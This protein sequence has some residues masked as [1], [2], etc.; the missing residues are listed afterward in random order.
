YP[1]ERGIGRAIA[2]AVPALTQTPLPRAVEEALSTG[3]SR[4]V[5][6]LTLS[7][8]SSRSR[9]LEVRVLPVSDGVTLLWQDI[10]ERAPADYALKRSE[11]RLILA[12]EGANDG[13]WELDLRT[14][15]FYVSGRW[16]AM[17]GLTPAAGVRSPQERPQRAPPA[18]PPRVKDARD[19]HIAAKTD[20]C[21]REHRMRHEDGSY[22]R[23]LCRGIAARGAG[24]RPMRIAGSLTDTTAQ[25]TAQEQLRTAEYRDPLTGLCNSAVFVE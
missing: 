11:E 5:A 22:R 3:Q 4:T 2:A 6:P 7:A 13:L 19:A 1:R 9:I 23:F 15:A 21:E 10:S 20:H 16:K 18:H 25:A 14:Y 24:Q 8:P 17:L 12:A